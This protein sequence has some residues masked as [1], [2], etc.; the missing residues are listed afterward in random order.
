LKVDLEEIVYS[1][2][3]KE[4][5]LTI[6]TLKIN[7]NMSKYRLKDYLYGWRFVEV[8]LKELINEFKIYVAYDE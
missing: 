8:M 2:K 3:A 5:T 4:T 1:K 7:T 6:A